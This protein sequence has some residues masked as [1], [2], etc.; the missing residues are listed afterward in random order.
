LTVNA[1]AADAG[2][3]RI[4]DVRAD[5]AA[6]LG[7]PPEAIRDDDDLVRLGLDSISVMRLAGGWRLAGAKVSFAE[8]IERRTLAEW[9]RLLSDATPGGNSGAAAP[10]VPE[11]D[12][13]AAFVLTP[14]QH[15]YWVGRAGGP[16]LGGVGAHFYNE[17]D[18]R[19][20]VPERLQGAVRQVLRRH[21]M[22]RAVIGDDGTQQIRPVSCWP[23]LSVHDLRGSPAAAV[24]AELTQIRERMSHRR[25]RVR[26][27][28]V[29]DVALSM[30]PGGATRVHLQI[31]MLV[32]DAH[33]FRV[34]LAD[35][36]RAYDEPDEQLPR[37]GLSYPRYLALAAGGR[38]AERA[39]ARAYWQ[40]RLD[41]LPGPPEL[42][43]AADP[44]RLTG[45]RVARHWHPLDRDRSALLARRARG[46]GLTLPTVFLTAFTEV[47]GAWSATPR[48]LLNLPFYDRQP[49]HP[50]V[51]DL[52]GD[53]TSLLLFAVDVTEPCAF[54]ER[55]R[56]VQEQ[57]HSDAA[58]GAYS[59]IEILRDLA[60]RHGGGPAG[61]PVVFTSALNLGELFSERARHCFGAPGWTM[62]QTPQVWLDHQVTERED[63]LFFNWD[64][65]AGLFAPGVVEDMFEAYLRLLDWLLAEEAAWDRAGPELLPAAASEV[66]RIVNATDRP[67]HARCLHDDFFALAADAPE[68]VAVLWGDDGRLGYGELAERAGLVAAALIAAGTAPGDPVAVTL[69][70]GPDQ[71]AAVLG[72]LRAGGMYV[73]VSADQPIERRNRI[74]TAAGVRLVLAEPGLAG[75]PAGVRPVALPRAG[76]VIPRPVGVDPETPAYMLFTSGS[77]GTPKGVEV[78]HRAALNTLDDLRERFAIGAGDRTLAV[79]ALDF[80]LSVFDIFGPLSVGG[81]VVFV[82]EIARRDAA[83]WVELVRRWTVTVW[84]S[85]PALLD[86]LLTAADG[87]GSALP[88]RLALLGGDWV[89]LDLTAR[90]AAR[91]PGSRL[92]ALG[93]TTETAI[94]STVQPV[95]AEVPAGW[96]SVPYGRPLHNQRLRVVDTQGRDRPDLVPGELWIGGRSVA[97]GYRGDPARTARHFVTFRGERW[98]RTG[99]LAR[100]WPDGTVEFL[101]RA[102]RQV[103]IRG[104]RIEPGE[105]ESALEAE[106]LVDRAVVVAAGEGRRR[107]L[108]AAVLA[109]AGSRP[110][111][112]RL[113]GALADQLPAYLV[114]AQVFVVDA[115]PLSA[116]GKVDRTRLTEMLDGAAGEATGGPPAGLAEKTAAAIWS[117]LFGGKTISRDDSFFALGGDS[118]L[119]TQM[120][121]ELRS[122]GLLGADLS[123]LFRAPV[124]AE[125][126]ATLRPAD[127]P[128]PPPVPLAA[129]PARRYEPFPATD[130]QRAYWFG[131]TDDFALGG[132]GSHWYWEFDGVDVDL[133]GLEDAV[134]MLVTRHDML[135]AI[136]DV[137]GRQRVLP[138]VPRFEIMVTE[139]DSML[140]DMREALSHRVPDPADW[141]LMAIRAVRY[142]ERRTRV[143]FS[144]DYIVLDALSIVT[145]FG[146]LAT[147]YR[148][149]RTTLP[150]VEVTFRD[151]VLGAQPPAEELASA[152]H[153]W[154]DRIDDLPEPPRLPLAENPEMVGALRFRRRRARL[155]PERWRGLTSRARAS[156]V[157][158]AAVLAAAYAEVLSA[159][160]GQ[161]ALTLNVTMFDRRPV[162]AHI[163]RVLGDFTSLLLVAYRAGAS[164]GWLDLARRMQHEIWD[165]MTHSAASAIWVL[166]EMARRAQVP[167]VSMP[168]VFTSALGLARDLVDLSFPFGHLVWGISQTPQVWLDN[169]VMERAGGLEYNWDSVDALFPEG[170]VDAMFAAY[171]RLL[172]W[173]CTADWTGPM[174]DLLPI[175][176]REVR[177]EANATAGPLPE[178]ALHETFFSRAA[179]DP[180]QPA[181]FWDDDCARTYG[182]LAAQALRIAGA[183]AAHGLS[184]GE[185]VAVTLPPG[186]DQIAAVLGVLA[187]GGSYVPIGTGEPP[188]RQQ[189]IR[190]RA[191]VRLTVGTGGIA[192]DVAGPALPAPVPVPPDSLAYTIFTSGST[193]EPKGV[194][195]THRAAGNTIDDINKRFG[196]GPGDRVLAVSALDFDLSVYDIFGLLSVGGAVVCV[197]DADRREA[198]SW[199]RL[200]R[201]HG[202]SVWNS[203]PALLDMVLVAAGAEP[204]SGVRVVLASG[205]WVG[206]DLPH[207]VAE[208]AP[209][210]RFVALGGA[211]EAAI[212]SNAIEVPAVRDDWRSIPYGR[213]LR[214]QRYRVVDG[215]GRDCPDWVTGELHIGGAGVARGYRSNPVATADRFVEDGAERWFRTGDLGRYWPDGTLEFLGRRDA[216]VKI[217]GHRIELGEIEAAAGLYPGIERAVAFTTGVVAS[218]RLALSVVPDSALFSGAGISA[219]LAERLPAYMVPERILVTSALPLTVNGK[220]DLGRL[221]EFAGAGRDEDEPPATA[222]EKLLAG[223]WAELL[224]REG[225]GRRQSFFALGGDSLL[226]T[227][228]VEALQRRL[229]ILLSLR[230]IFAAPTVAQLAALIDAE[231]GAAVGEEFEEGVL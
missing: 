43:L 182:E 78:P 211:T 36:A 151:Y 22:L 55:A 121:G 6:A 37:I 16:P 156:D 163:D 113:R 168:V 140:A 11:I 116:N 213:P 39:R 94:H 157:T 160:S 85:V 42:P 204:L 41:D 183:L 174:P 72:V 226:A 123:A 32:A 220:V 103:K 31:E 155:S 120:L 128:P 7:E 63:G 131:R 153:Y 28:E 139:G 189:R 152:R 92:I 219:F 137:D 124:L 64:V 18:G 46:Y 105:V 71:V 154:R 69:P 172:D 80:D 111:P 218:R 23:G 222:T 134:N 148:D 208:V 44:A 79:S 209:G 180:H 215:R 141:P 150:P 199:V 169:Q 104:H 127:V 56:R 112:G 52:V 145:F 62:S 228:L 195:I 65:A 98:Y 114:P 110:E 40:R 125:F 10:P 73:P 164:R 207:R 2:A 144:L 217:R 60:R 5:I 24:Q 76:L 49:V 176:Q 96:R 223:I 158:P 229:G 146:E 138:A 142:G 66:R 12:G 115:L 50:E 45:H 118:L 19:D 1:G 201:R 210:A 97:L 29:F 3:L 35:L 95:P 119:A 230:Q 130:V 61:A 21:G 81:A 193:G 15:A 102:D 166:R 191:D 48:F 132:V 122:A 214:N 194:E 159:W 75:L 190:E 27:G 224:E 197:D 126:A 33:S 227:R 93:G 67:V 231:C 13:S 135:R 47:L 205:D 89:G 74:Y 99:D 181:V 171:G 225:I 173:L 161:D 25:L 184:P 57:L 90:L 4:E 216:Q 58:H 185:S 192:A 87:T 70:R 9:W 196:V 109:A 26:D 133:T 14:M 77:T 91:A 59:G 178:V 54:A 84:Q 101:G 17:F 30:L 143:G 212:W 206:L 34:L 136:F 167:A 221:A 187:A 117:R 129:D 82:D 20:V 108:V 107:F 8:L 198:R 83:R 100:Y 179:S 177:A 170:V 202:V 38:D 88:L 165:G 203:V 149:L 86:M 186:P 188:A 53:F 162:H 106:P 68:R 175:A 200:I 147:L 51:D